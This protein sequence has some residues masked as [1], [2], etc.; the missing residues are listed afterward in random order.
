MVI[1][2]NRQDQIPR[3]ALYLMPRRKSDWT[4][5]ERVEIERIRTAYD[6][7]EWELECSYTD[8]GDPWCIIYDHD[9]HR[10][11]LHLARIDRR[12]FVVWPAQ[13]RSEEAAAMKAAVDL[14]IAERCDL[15][16]AS[17]TK[18]SGII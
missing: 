15:Y 3:T 18:K 8:E 11:I 2:K 17:R 10:V 16:S 13:L 6:G 7:P 12:Y 1:L 5:E 14:I 4:A 9:R